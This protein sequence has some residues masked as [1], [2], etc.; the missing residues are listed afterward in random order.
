MR[1]QRLH[2]IERSGSVFG[3]LVAN[4]LAKTLLVSGLSS[5]MLAGS[6]SSVW[7][8]Q[9]STFPPFDPAKEEQLTDLAIAQVPAR[10]MQTARATAP[11]VFFQSAQR[12]WKD[13][14]LVYRVEGRLYREVWHLHI[15][16]D[17]TLLR[18]ETDFQDDATP[19]GRGSKEV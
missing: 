4:R 11:D 2:A 13:D 1:R 7:A 8:Q 5:L 9:S 19:A 15:R 12:F 17:G 18:T 16:Q 6:F 14:F 10:V 3:L